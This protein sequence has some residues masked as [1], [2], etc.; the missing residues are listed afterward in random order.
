MDIGATLFQRITNRAKQV[1]NFLYYNLCECPTHINVIVTRL[2]FIQSWSMLYAASAWDPYTLLNINKLESIQRTT[3]RFCFNDF[4]RY[5]GVTN[6]LS[7]LIIPL[8]QEKLKLNLVLFY[9]IIGAVH[10]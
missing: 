8:L 1:N 9:K 4:S 3:A 7:S 6:M 10:R 5:S 2:W